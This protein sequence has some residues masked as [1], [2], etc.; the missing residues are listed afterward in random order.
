[1]QT[2]AVKSLNQVH[3]AQ[4]SSHHASQKDPAVYSDP[5]FRS[6]PFFNDES[7]IRREI[8]VIQEESNSVQSAGVEKQLNPNTVKIRNRINWSK[9][10]SGIDLS[11][12]FTIP[13]RQIL[14]VMDE[15]CSPVSFSRF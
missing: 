1:M 8:K 12:L 6:N 11:E 5:M 15:L 10:L 14:Y 2:S 13:S 9:H 3:K 7:T 4:V